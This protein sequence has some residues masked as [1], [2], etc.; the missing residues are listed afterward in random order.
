[1]QIIFTQ[2]AQLDIYGEL[3]IKLSTMWNFLVMPRCMA[4]VPAIILH[5]IYDMCGRRTS[6]VILWRRQQSQS[7][8]LHWRTNS[9][10]QPE[11]TNTP[12]AWF[13]DTPVKLR[14]IV[15]P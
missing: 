10:T 7:T 8:D 3:T 4:I 2:L 12:R 15:F 11:T 13:Q 14:T 5:C 1:M 6:F 9:Q